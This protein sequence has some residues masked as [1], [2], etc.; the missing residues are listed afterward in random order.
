MVQP[1]LPQVALLDHTDVVVTHGGNNTITEALRAGRPMV[2][3]PFSTDQFAGAAAV[4]QAGLGL[5]L[6]P[7]RLTVDALRDA[8]AT[9]AGAD[10]TARAALLGE[11]LRSQPGAE[12]AASVLL[13]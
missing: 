3:L 12:V 1:S 4:E 7:N 6:D 8:V 9:V 11:R 5:V 10:C 13:A 2:V